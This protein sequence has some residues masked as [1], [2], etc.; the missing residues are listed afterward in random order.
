MVVNK[1]PADNQT[2]VFG[3]N[4]RLQSMA[5]KNASDDGVNCC[6][7]AGPKDKDKLQSKEKNRR[8]MIEFENFLQNKIYVKNKQA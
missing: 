2:S 5:G 7:C 8:Y 4:A 3:N 6:D 1:T